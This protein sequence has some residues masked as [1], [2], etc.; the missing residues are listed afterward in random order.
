MSTKSF[1]KRAIP[2]LVIGLLVSLISISGLLRSLDL[3]ISDLRM[4]LSAKPASGTIVYVAIDDKSLK[5]IG[6]WPWPRSL[7]ASLLD[8]L[9]EAGARDV[10]F[11]YRLRLRE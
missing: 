8:H 7:H 10:F 3:A 1:A 2:A 11:R 6:R 5:E 4:A 9:T